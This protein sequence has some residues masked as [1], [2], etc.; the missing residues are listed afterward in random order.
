M[1][2]TVSEGSKRGR[3]AAPGRPASRAATKGSARFKLWKPVASVVTALLLWEMFARLGLLPI[4]VSS[5]SAV[6]ERLVADLQSAPLW[7]ALGMTAYHWLVALLL[8]SLVGISIGVISGLSRIVDRLLKGVIEFVRPIPSVIYLPM[9]LLLVGATD[10]TVYVLAALGAVWP[11]LYQTYYAIKNLDPI[12]LD[13]GRVFHLTRFERLRWILLPALAPSVATGIR[14]AS[15]I[16][17]IVSITIELISG[18]PGLGSTLQHASRN[19]LYPAM[20]GAILIIGLLGLLLNV[21]MQ[22][23]ERRAL[24]W[25]ESHRVRI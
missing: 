19:A 3:A 23:L 2:L 10:G 13:T 20:Y 17:L 11:V 24:R 6:A 8:A 16:A 14:I 18:V 25:H 22:A 9:V 7:I 15:A 4:E 21:G 5:P 1:T 12:I